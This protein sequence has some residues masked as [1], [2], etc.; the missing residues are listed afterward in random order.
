MN[1]MKELGHDINNR[2]VKVAQENVT[3][4]GTYKEDYSNSFLL[5]TQGIYILGNKEH[6]TP[7]QRKTLKTGDIITFT[8][9]KMEELENTLI[10]KETLAPL[11]SS[12]FTERVAKS[13]RVQTTRDQVQHLSKIVYG[14]SKVLD[15]QMAEIFQNPDSGQRLA[16][17]IERFPRA[18]ASLTGFDLFFFK[19]SGRTNAQDH[20]N[21]LSS[22]IANYADAVKHTRFAITQEHHIEQNRRGKAIEK[23][24]QNLQDLFCLSPEKQTELLS[25]SPLLYQELRA[26]IRCLEHRLSSNESSAI[27][28]NDHETLA[29]SLGVSEQ[30]AQEISDIVQKATKAHQ[31]VFTRKLNRSNTLAMAS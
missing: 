7:E 31:Q 22:A 8:A 21:L 12:E 28:R 19:T 25:Q 24:S 18:I 20:V 11:T 30:K 6:L 26:F 15:D 9:L 17:R 16:R 13:P 1:D 2:L 29:K 4:L 27:K 3:Y 5:D 14:S 23:P 10:P